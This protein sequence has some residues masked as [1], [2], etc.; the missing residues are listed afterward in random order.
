M[1]SANYV[2]KPRVVETA[3]KDTPERPVGEVEPMPSRRCPGECAP[4]YGIG[5][6]GHLDYN[7]PDTVG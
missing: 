2:A 4:G 7:D 1:I 3:A 5:R 6:D